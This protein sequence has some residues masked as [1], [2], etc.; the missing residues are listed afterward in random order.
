ME[1]DS[2]PS[3]DATLGDV[4]RRREVELDIRGNHRHGMVVPASVTTDIAVAHPGLHM[5]HSVLG[6]C[7]EPC[8]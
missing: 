4:Q 2:L 3:H 7:A 1:S 8:S 5:H 6:Q